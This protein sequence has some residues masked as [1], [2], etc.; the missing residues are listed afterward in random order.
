MYQIFF[1]R[2]KLFEVS[3]KYLSNLLLP[4]LLPMASSKYSYFYAD[5]VSLLIYE[6]WGGTEV[7][8]I[9]V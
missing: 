8:G 1:S 3:F 5:F 6:S 2:V 4:L 9:M 7:I